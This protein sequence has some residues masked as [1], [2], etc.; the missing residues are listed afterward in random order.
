VAEH[1]PDLADQVRR[2]F[3][4]KGAY[5]RFK[6]LLDEKRLL[7]AWHAFEGERQAQALRQWCAANGIEVKD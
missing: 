1:G 6:D 3:G 7:D 4:R 5:G 2:I